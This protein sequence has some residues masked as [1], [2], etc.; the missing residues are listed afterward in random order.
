MKSTVV[1]GL[2]GSVL[3]AGAGA[4]RWDRWRPSVGLCQH[5]S[6]LIHRFELLHPPAHATLALPAAPIPCNVTFF[7]TA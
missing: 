2:L 1:L 6:L 7:V 3:D 5:E 4:G